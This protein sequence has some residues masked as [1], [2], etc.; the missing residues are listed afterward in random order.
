MLRNEDF[1]GPGL[2]EVGFRSYA[3]LTSGRRVVIRRRVGER[4]E[5]SPAG[6]KYF[7]RFK[8][9]VIAHVPVLNCFRNK[10]GTY[11][12]VQMSHSYVPINDERFMMH[13]RTQ[14]G[15]GH[16]GHAHVGARAT[17]DQIREGVLGELISYLDW[18]P[19][20]KDSV[21][22]YAALGLAS[23]AD[24]H[25]VFWEYDGFVTWDESR[26]ITF[27]ERFT[28]LER[29]G[30]YSVE[31]FLD[32]PLRAEEPY[33]P[34]ELQQQG[35]TKLAFCGLGNC[36]VRQ[37]AVCFEKCHH[38]HSG[39]H[40]WQPALTPEDLET[41]MDEAWAELNYKEG[42][43]PFEEAEGLQGGWREHGVTMRMVHKVVDRFSGAALLYSRGRLVH[44]YTSPNW[45]PD[46]HLPVIAIQVHGCHGFVFDGPTSRRRLSHDH[47]VASEGL[48]RVSLQPSEASKL[49][50]EVIKDFDLQE[51]KACIAADTP[52]LMFHTYMSGV[53]DTL[54]REK[55][56]FKENYGS[57]AFAPVSLSIELKNRKRFVVRSRPPEWRLLQALCGQI[58]GYSFCYTG[59]STATLTLQMLHALVTCSRGPVPQELRERLRQ[60]QNCECALCSAPLPRGGQR[61]VHLDHIQPLAEGGT[62]SEENLRLLCC[63][64]HDHV[65]Q[66]QEEAQAALQNISPFRGL[67]SALSPRVQKLFEEK[68]RQLSGCLPGVKPKV[69]EGLDICGCR[70]NALEQASYPLPVLCWA[71]D[72]EEIDGF[73]PGFDFYLVRGRPVWREAVELEL[74]YRL[75]KPEDIRWAL[76]ASGHVAPERFKAACDDI[77]GA[78]HGLPEDLFLDED[79]V[80]M[81]P[82]SMAKRAILSAIGLMNRTEAEK[83]TWIVTKSEC[84]GDHPGQG[85]FRR[86]ENG[87]WVL[88]DKQFRR[89]YA[90]SWRPVGQ[91]ALDM[92]QAR[93]KQLQVLLKGSYIYAYQVDCV[94]FE[95]LKAFKPEEIIDKVRYPSGDPV[96]KL[97]KKPFVPKWELQQQEDSK[98][99]EPKEWRVSEELGLEETLDLVLES[100]GAFFSGPPG[101]GKTFR[102]QSLMARLRFLG[103]R[104]IPMSFTHAASHILGGLVAETVTH[105]VQSNVRGMAYAK[106][107]WIFLDEV[108]Q[109]PLKL[110]PLL[111]NYKILG[112]RF[113]IGGDFQQMQPIGE[114]WREA[115]EKAEWCPA[116]WDLSGGL[117]FDLTTCRRSDVEHFEFY[118]GL[119]KRV[120]NQ[121]LLDELRRRY[122]WRGEP[123]DVVLVMSHAKRARLALRLNAAQASG[124][125]VVRVEPSEELRQGQ[126]MAPHPYM[127]LWEGIRLVGC[128]RDSSD[129]RHIQNNCVYR[130]LSV[131][132]SQVIVCLDIEEVLPLTLTRQETI[133]FLRLDCARCYASIQGL[134]L[135]DQRLL[136][137]DVGHR[138]QDL[139]KLCV[140]CSRVTHGSFLHVATREQEKAL[141]E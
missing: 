127:L 58:K 98:V 119:P 26:A 1:A 88:M 28:H 120:L 100:S 20:V 141:L 90:Q 70:S 4:I 61:S 128:R 41:L 87:Q 84:S 51:L 11:R 14:R 65:T 3:H 34:S 76:K 69:L 56:P 54:R 99:F 133:Q 82:K 17:R 60:K 106:Y 122:I 139:R 42:F 114:V 23:V 96:F 21:E 71:D 53:M 72:F 80:Q 104:V 55:I 83:Y 86:F 95:R 48:Q 107:T 67:C 126:T 78:L 112:C 9:E 43:Y 16:L 35:L 131:D 33:W 75:I 77:R 31:V 113:V 73:K 57:S 7:A 64:C 81:D 94:V 110:L 27:D 45:A 49:Q 29:D 46:C 37:M 123:V 47:V 18:L 134:T 30:H 2:E 79:G 12:V 8:V 13:A 138:F 22:G 108:S 40:S 103:F 93:M 68:P 10:N 132:S 24:S 105:F 135:R 121:D 101:V 115:L 130:V 125:E 137:C 39:A 109:C 140:A 111:H 6:K 92:E 38:R 102:M 59:Q 117:R 36:V 91:V 19:K 50:P 85:A 124:R 116:M 44:R 97:D 89:S 74:K 52:G 136:L 66:Q 129:H 25:I 118:T 62:D 5:V 63:Y 32:R 15:L